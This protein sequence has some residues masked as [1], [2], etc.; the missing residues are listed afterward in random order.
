MTLDEFLEIEEIK[1]LKY[2]YMRCVDLKLWDDLATVFVP[3]ATVSYSAG[4]YSYEGRDEILAWLKQGM[5]SDGFHSTHSVHHPEIDLT[6]PDTATGIW[7]L[8]D[9]VVITDHDIVIS[10]A[11]FYHDRYVKQGAVWRFAERRFSMIYS[12]PPDL[13]AK[14]LPIAPA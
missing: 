9:T 11:A 2:K 6:G 5:E 8:E 14:P 13:S 3:E 4:H 12:G 1:R 7:K 10:G